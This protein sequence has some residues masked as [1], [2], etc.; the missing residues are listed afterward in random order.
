MSSSFQGAKKKQ[1]SSKQGG[2]LGDEPD[3]SEEDEYE[4]SVGTEMSLY[5]LDRELV[6]ATFTA[7]MFLEFL[8]SEQKSDK[9]TK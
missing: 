7:E 1:K 9:K 6:L 4:V 5:S 8:N 3:E 2:S